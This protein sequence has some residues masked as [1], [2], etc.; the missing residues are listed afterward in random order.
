[1]RLFAALDVPEEVAG[2]LDAAV[3]PLRERFGG[4]RWTAADRWHLTVAFLGEV[5]DSGEGDPLERVEEA[6]APAAGAAPGPVGLRLAEPGRFGRRVLWVGVEDDPQGAVAAL[7]SRAQ[8]ELGRARLPVDTKPVHAHL[9]LARSRKAAPVRDEVLEALPWVE[10]SWTATD[11]VVF[12]SRLGGG[13]PPRYE[14]VLRLPL[15]G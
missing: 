11:L 6:L 2:R 14:A 10:A 1:M 12:R 4:L 9:T 3:A 5:K 8:E 13:G 7:G 15:G